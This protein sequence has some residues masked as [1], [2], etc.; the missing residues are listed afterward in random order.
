MTRRSPAKTGRVIG[1]PLRRA[2]EKKK[3]ILAVTGSFGSGKSTVAA[4]LRTPAVEVIDAD[5]VARR[6][7]IPGS[8][9]YRRVVRAFGRGII[10]RCGGINRKALAAAVFSDRKAL[11]EL[12]RITHPAIIRA[13]AEQ[14]RKTP[15]S[16]VLLEAPLLFEAGI[17]DKVDAVVVVKASRNIIIKRIARKR[18]LDKKEISRRLASQLPISYKVRHADFVIDNNG[19]LK[20]TERR[21]KRIRRIVW[22]NWI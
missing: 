5:K 19:P 15:K 7:F 3:R 8:S 9:V 13:I 2:A 18:S 12:N 11:D 14:I 4:F 10:G 6:L 20:E 17:R 22:K 21:A 1:L 16:A